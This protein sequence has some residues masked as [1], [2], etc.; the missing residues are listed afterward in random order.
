MDHRVSSYLI[1]GYRNVPG[2]H[3]GSTAMRNL[4]QHYCG[5]ELT[6]EEVFGLGSGLDF[7]IMETEL[8]APGIL[9]FGRGPT[10]EVDVADALAVD[11]QEQIE[12]D[13]ER[14]WKVVKGEVLAG[15]PTMLSG[16]IFYLDY[17]KS[18]VHFPAHR[19]VLVGFEDDKETAWIADRRDPEPQACSYVGLRK[20][21]NPPDFMST[22]NTWGKF[23]GTEVGRS[24]PEAFEHAIGKTVSRM[25]GEST[26]HTQ[27][28]ELVARGKPFRL[29]TG[30]AGLEHLRDMIPDWAGSELAPQSARYAAD[31][32]E[33]FGTGGGN[34]RNLYAGFLR[35][36]HEHA[37]HLV[38]TSTHEV[39]THA[40]ELWTQLSKAFGELAK[41]PESFD[42]AATQALVDSIIQS[43]SRLVDV[44]AAAPPR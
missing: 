42:V 8:F 1:E 6:E 13:D 17:R 18:K 16:D 38:G 40:A 2:E 33:A 35:S 20:S 15:R 39:A 12:L 9:M 24:L 14:A 29:T 22:F 32:I 27:I 41:S 44:L 37:P 23:Y 31:C 36:A 34:F 28:F 4:L 19:Y 26:G 43:E 3:C 11:Y 7:L 25:R 30:L 10:M 21:R 5:L